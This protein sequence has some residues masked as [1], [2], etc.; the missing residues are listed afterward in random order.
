[1]EKE[2]VRRAGLMQFLFYFAL[3][4]GS[5]Y[6]VLY[7][8][9]LLV[10]QYGNT[11]YEYIGVI[12]L[13]QALIAFLSPLIAGYIADKYQITNRLISFCAFGV[14]L[15]AAITILP[16]LAPFFRL[17][18]IQRLWLLFPGAM[19][20]QFFIRPLVPLI[21]TGT[22][23]ALED[24]DGHADYYGRVR[25]MG[26]IGWIICCLMMGRWLDFSGR[27][28]DALIV[29]ASVYAVLGLISLGGFSTNVRRVDLTWRYL[30]EDRILRVLIIVTFVRMIG[31]GMGFIYTGVF[32]SEMNLNY[33]QMGMAF[34]L[35]ALLEIPFFFKGHL[36]RE[37]WGGELLILCDLLLQALRFFIFF[38]FPHVQNS[39]FYIAVQLLSGLGGLYAYYGN[40]PPVEPHRSLPSESHVP[41]YIHRGYGS[42]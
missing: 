14:A 9:Q 27:L 30:L 31:F 37:R 6:F 26:S 28:V 42:G 32:L 17:T 2:A 38:M 35:A 18:F 5:N 20:S 11:Q 8:K 21:D 41:E 40:N 7:Y 36:L 4:G 19:V 33:T 25:M 1:M 10:D 12:L 16:G 15:G 13:A 3:A 23:K 22:L 29:Y 34:G 24:L 39:Y